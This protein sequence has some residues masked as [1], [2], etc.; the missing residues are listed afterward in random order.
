[1]RQYAVR[2]K[3]KKHRLTYIVA[4]ENA[5]QAEVRAYEQAPD[6]YEVFRTD[7]EGPYRTMRVGY[8]HP[9][10]NDGDPADEHGLTSSSGAFAMDREDT[11]WER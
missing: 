11:R 3:K 2:M 4:A 5:A 7:D 10:E 1:M 8:S 6:G 9:R